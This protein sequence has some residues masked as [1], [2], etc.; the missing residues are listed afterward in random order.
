MRLREFNQLEQLLESFNDITWVIYEAQGDTVVRTAKGFNLSDYDAL[1]IEKFKDF[2]EVK[3]NTLDSYG[4]K[5]KPMV[6]K[7]PLGR[8]IPGLMHAHLTQDASVF[9]KIHGRDPRYLDIY[10]VF[11]HKDLGLGNTPNVKKQQ[12]AAKRFAKVDF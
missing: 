12:Q 4:A 2:V 3:R 1:V 9:Y 11:R 10:G 5:D 7:A 8:A 6:S